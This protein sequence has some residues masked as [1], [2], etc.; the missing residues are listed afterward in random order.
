M[1]VDT[2]N[3]L[4]AFFEAYEQMQQLLEGSEPGQ[5]RSDPVKY[6]ALER[7][8]GIMAIATKRLY[9]L[10][11][12][13]IPYYSAVLKLKNNVIWEFKPLRPGYLHNIT[14]KVLPAVYRFFTEKSKTLHTNEN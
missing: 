1:D 14:R 4:Q 5:I 6:R 12:W 3:Q 10:T 7:L 9:K 11:G 2:Q 8:L 13:Q